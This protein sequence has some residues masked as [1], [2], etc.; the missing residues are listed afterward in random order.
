VIPRLWLV[1]DRHL[2]HDL[3]QAVRRAFAVLDA[4]EVALVLR[5]K[6]LPTRDLLALAS[7]LRD[8]TGAAGAKLVVSGRFDVAL[9]ARAD[10]VHLG[11]EAPPSSA[12]RA[13]T[14]E[15]LLIGASL[16]GEETPPPGVDYVFLSPVFATTSKPGAAPMGIEGLQRGVRRA[17][18]PVVALGGVD[19]ARAAACFAAGAAGVALRS[20]W[21]TADNAALESLRGALEAPR[22]EAPLAAFRTR[23]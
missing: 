20:G 15:T 14:G 1:T 21:L 3:P 7:T 17:D 13:A 9:A 19:P 2:A 23:H 8:L 16:H 5:E 11:R 6:D 18:V 12:V 10:G 4:S 22:G